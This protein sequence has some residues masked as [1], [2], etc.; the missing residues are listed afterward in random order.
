VAERDYITVVETRPF[1]EDAARC[2]KDDERE[3]FIAYISREPTA[4]VLIPGTG[5]VRKIRWRAGGRG[6]R[7]GA[8]VIYCYRSERMPL[9]L[10]TAYSKSSQSDL[11]PAQR[12]AMR[13]I[14][15]EIV[16]QY[17]HAPAKRR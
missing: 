16:K 14:V 1:I 5:G 6:K 9:F 8:R 7:G 17:A 2:L 10:L 4:G 11:S 15:A 12:A 3:E 13:R